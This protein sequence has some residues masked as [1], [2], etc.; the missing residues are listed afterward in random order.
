MLVQVFAESMIY[1]MFISFFLSLFLFSLCLLWRINVSINP[2]IGL[3]KTSQLLRVMQLKKITS[4]ERIP[5]GSWENKRRN[6]LYSSNCIV[7]TSNILPFTLLND[8]FVV[9]FFSA[10]GAKHV[11]RALRDFARL[12][13]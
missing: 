11:S 3:I 9:I 1:V 7:N 12:Y 4:M 2:L 8:S 10:D 13:R 6:R 5:L